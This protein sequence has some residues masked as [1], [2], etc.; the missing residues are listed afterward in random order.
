MAVSHLVYRLEHRFS[1]AV[2]YGERLAL[3]TEVTEN[4]TSGAKALCKNGGRPCTPERRA[5]PVAYVKPV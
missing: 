5:P 4:I 1:G 2:R 3:A